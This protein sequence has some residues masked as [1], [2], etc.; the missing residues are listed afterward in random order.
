LVTNRYLTRTANWSNGSWTIGPQYQIDADTMVYFTASKGYST[1]GIGLTYPAPLQ[2]WQPETLTN[3][4]GGVKGTFFVGNTQIKTDVSGYYGFFDNTQV[5]TNFLLQIN[6]P[7]A[8]MSV[9]V[10][11][12]NAAT[13]RVSGVDAAVS[14]MLTDSLE[15]RAVAGYAR[16]WYVS[17]PSTDNL[18]NPV[19]LSSTPWGFSPKF[20]YTLSATY[21]LPLDESLGDI[22]ITGSY[23]HRTKFYTVAKP[24]ALMEGHDIV[25]PMENVDISVNWRSIMGNDSLDGNL[26]VT[27]VT[28]NTVSDGIYGGYAPSGYG[29]HTVAAPRMW[30]MRMTYNF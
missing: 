11:T 30:G 22:S 19:D 27:N 10:V 28:K 21:H 17:Y 15:L 24:R 16:N 4:E 29:T 6:P 1:G 3:L 9:V 2:V 13:A 5:T 26:F 14:V 23:F 12:A 8:P 20:K 25:P 7:P 18:G